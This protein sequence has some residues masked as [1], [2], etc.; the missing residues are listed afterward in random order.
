[1]PDPQNPDSTPLPAAD[2]I[3][4]AGTSALHS[5]KHRATTVGHGLR[6]DYND[7]IDRYK[8]TDKP[9]KKEI[10]KIWK[11]AP[12]EMRKASHHAVRLRTIPV[13]MAILFIIRIFMSSPM[14][15]LGTIF[16]LMS[17]LLILAAYISYKVARKRAISLARQSVDWIW[18]RIPTDNQA[19]QFERIY[20]ERNAGDLI[21]PWMKTRSRTRDWMGK[22][23]KSFIPSA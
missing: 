5:A 19:E 13:I 3:K 21:A 7:L 12:L 14:Q 2:R 15:L 8:A 17:I 9:L 23:L 16:S 1:M 18:E 20:A 6:Q 10:Q 22:K 11:T 4:R